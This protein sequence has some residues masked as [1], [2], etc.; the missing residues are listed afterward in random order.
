MVEYDEGI[1]E[2]LKSKCPH[3]EHWKPSKN[4]SYIRFQ[5]S[6]VQTRV[7]LTLMHNP[8]FFV[9]PS[10]LS[11]VSI[12]HGYNRYTLHIH[13]CWF[14][15]GVMTAYGLVLPSVPVLRGVL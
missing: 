4:I 6:S 5:F 11:A 3:I 12:R 13:H 9:D 14:F 8:V 2:L 15:E 10:G 1:V 7:Y